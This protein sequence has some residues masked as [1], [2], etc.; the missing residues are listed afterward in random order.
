MKVS[1]LERKIKEDPLAWG[2]PEMIRMAKQRRKS[3]LS[4][5][6]NDPSE[7]TSS[8][9]GANTASASMQSHTP[10]STSSIVERTSSSVNSESATYPEIRAK[11]DAKIEKVKASKAFSPSDKKA[12][13]LH[14]EKRYESEVKEKT[15]QKIVVWSFACFL[16]VVVTLVYVRNTVL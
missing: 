1:R 9:A 7:Y 11:Y 10:A 8:S 2:T 15:Y 13:I 5:D 14:L 16:V 3:G 6:L 4:V 12:R